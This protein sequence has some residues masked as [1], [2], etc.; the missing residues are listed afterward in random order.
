[1]SAAIALDRVT[2]RYGSTEAVRELSFTV[3]AGEM[4]GLIGPDGAGKTTTIKMIC[5]LLTADG[6]SARVLDLVH[7][8]EGRVHAPQRPDGRGAI[9]ARL[10]H[11]HR[12]RQQGRRSQAGHAG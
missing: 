6:G 1:M 4:F 11:S 9:E 12:R 7:L 5:G 10:P 8:A 3:D 2:K